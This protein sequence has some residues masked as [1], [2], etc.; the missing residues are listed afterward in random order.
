[1][2]E[3]VR[4][5]SVHYALQHGA[6]VLAIEPIPRLAE[7]LQ[8]T[9]RDEIQTGRVIILNAGIGK[10]NGYSNF[11]INQKEIYNSTFLD[12]IGIE[13]PVLTLDEI[14]KQGY[15]KKIDLIKMDI[16]GLEID[17]ILG[18]REV[19]SQSPK[20]ALAVYHS[21]FNAVEIEKIIKHWEPKY[22]VSFRGIFIRD[23]YGQPRPY[24]LHATR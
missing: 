12:G 18:A 2:L 14:L 21:F 22:K 20:L 3:L 17:A 16:E 5:F 6:N 11:Q 10:V 8:M 1:M 24:M 7:A 15:I 19:L 13:I 9:F 4:V 23:E